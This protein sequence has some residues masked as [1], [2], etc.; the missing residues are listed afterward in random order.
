MALLKV[1]AT[2][3]AQAALKLEGPPESSPEIQEPGYR[4]DLLIS[5]QV[6]ADDSTL[7][8][9]LGG[10]GSPQA[11]GNHALA[12]STMPQHLPVPFSVISSFQQVRD[13]RWTPW[14]H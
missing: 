10:G 6:L 9:D 14:F 3:C 11:Q 7:Y 5:D 8:G 13:S 2:L 12:P 1:T 4:Q